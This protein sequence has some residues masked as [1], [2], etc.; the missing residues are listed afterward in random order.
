[1]GCFFSCLCTPCTSCKSCLLDCCCCCD[2]SYL[3]VYIRSINNLKIKPDLDNEYGDLYIRVTYKGVKQSSDIIFDCDKTEMISNGIILD[4]CY[5]NCD[6]NETILME[7]I[8]YDM[9]TRDDVLGVCHIEAPRE[10]GRNMG[11]KKYRFFDSDGKCVGTVTMDQIHFI[12]K[13]KKR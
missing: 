13:N 3:H 11:E 8:D 6:G 5:P 10:Y 1:M 7:L 4:N 9:I 2:H 12:K